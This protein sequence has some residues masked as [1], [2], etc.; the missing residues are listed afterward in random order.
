MHLVFSDIRSDRLSAA[1][2]LQSGAVHSACACVRSHVGLSLEECLL[3]DQCGESSNQG[4]SRLRN[5]SVFAVEYKSEITVSPENRA[6]QY[7][8]HWMNK[9]YTT[10]SNICGHQHSFHPLLDGLLL[11]S[12]DMLTKQSSRASSRVGTKLGSG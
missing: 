5:C 3:L 4:G 12:S 1:M 7:F 2:H 6:A 9:C 11:S 10:W 8:T